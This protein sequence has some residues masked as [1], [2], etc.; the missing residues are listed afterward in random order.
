MLHMILS[1]LSRRLRR[2][3]STTRTIEGRYARLSDERRWIVYDARTET[4]T[5]ESFDY[6]PTI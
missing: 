6:M 1:S 4:P 5:G 2:D 3:R